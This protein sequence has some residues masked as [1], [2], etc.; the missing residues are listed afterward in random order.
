MR[1][2]TFHAI[3]RML[4]DGTWHAVEDLRDVTSLPDEWVREL[5]AEGLI[6]TTE[7]VGNVLVRLRNP[8]RNSSSA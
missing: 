2:K 6:E 8:R 5:Q 1:T 4:A 3:T 7:Q